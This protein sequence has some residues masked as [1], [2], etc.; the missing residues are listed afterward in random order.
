MPI[1]KSRQDRLFDIINVTAITTVTLV[2]LYPLIFVVSASISDPLA[3]NSGRVF[4]WPRNISLESYALVLQES[5]VWR[6][7]RNTIF[8]VAVDVLLSLVV[9]LPIAYS[10][11]RPDRLK[12][13]RILT[14]VVAFTMIFHA[15]IIPTYLVVKKL[16]W[17]NTVWAITVPN[18][19]A[20]YLIIITRTFLQTNVPRE[21]YDAAEMDGATFTQTFFFVAIPLCSAIIAVLALFRGV[22]QWNSF[23]QPLIYLTDSEKFPLQ[24]VL[25][26][27]LL[28]NEQMMEGATEVIDTEALAALARRSILAE[29]MKYSLI[30]ISSAP[31]LMVYPFL[32]KYLLKGV[33][34]GA[35]KG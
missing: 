33:M 16:G 4:L 17:V 13:S 7:Y 3:V 26:N 1:G 29:T 31:V 22:A 6:G 10:L 15:G 35:I 9:I 8:Y 27:I 23:F 30:V 2:V 14:F 24:L 34:L 11:S 19:V 18:T 12:G 5:Q 21:L 25:R 32:Q 28:E 20:P